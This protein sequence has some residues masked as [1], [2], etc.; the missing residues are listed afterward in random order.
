MLIL[1]VVWASENF[2]YYL[3]GAHFTL[4]MDQQALV[5]A[6]KEN[7]ENKTYQSRQIKW[8]DRLLPFHFSHEHIPGKNRGFVDYLSRNPTALAA[9]SQTKTKTFSSK[10]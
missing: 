3:Y 7:R 9:P 6:L 5:S 2:K 8:V 4:Q 1:E 10:L